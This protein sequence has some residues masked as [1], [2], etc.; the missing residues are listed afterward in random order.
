ME[1]EQEMANEI[2]KGSLQVASLVLLSDVISAFL[3]NTDTWNLSS[4]VTFTFSHLVS[5]G[6]LDHGCGTA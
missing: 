5:A 2:N 4:P 1:P 6:G 3:S